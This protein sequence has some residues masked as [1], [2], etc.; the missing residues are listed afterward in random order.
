[1]IDNILRHGNELYNLHI[2]K[3]FSDKPRYLLASELPKT[4]RISNTQ[5]IS[6]QSS[7]FTGLISARQSEA[8][9]LTFSISDG[10]HRCFE[11]SAYCLMTIGKGGSCGYTTAVVKVSDQR[12]L[13]FDSHARDVKGLRSVSGKAVV[14]QASSVLRF[15]QYV[16]DLSK[17][18][19]ADTLI[20]FEL[21]VVSVSCD[22]DDH[23]A[24]Y[25][26]I[27]GDS[28]TNLSPDTLVDDFTCTRKPANQ[29]LHKVKRQR[30][31]ADVSS[32][33]QTRYTDNDFSVFVPV[34]NAGRRL[35]RCSVCFEHQSVATL[36]AAKKNQLPVICTESGTVPRKELL[37]LHLES[38]MHKECV[39][40]QHI[41]KLQPDDP[42]AHATPPVKQMFSI[43]QQKIAGKITGCLYTVFNDAKR[44][45]LS[46]WSWPSR[47]VAHM[48]GT[49]AEQSGLT[50]VS[51]SDIP[52]TNL[53]YI[54]PQM[55]NELLGCIVEADKENVKKKVLNSLAI[56]LRADGSVD[57]TQIDNVHV[58]AKIVTAEGCENNIFLGFKEPESR[59]ADGY[60]TALKDAVEFIVE[61]KEI[62]PKVTSI[63]TDGASINVGDKSGLWA[64]LQKLRDEVEDS[65]TIPLLKIWCTVHRSSL[66][67]KSACSNVS[68]L[69]TLL[70]D[71]TGLAS[72]FRQSG[73]R[74]HEL[75][76][77]AKQKGFPVF[78][79]PKY[80]EVRW[81]EFT[82]ALCHA[83]VG[84]WRAIVTYL[85]SS[86]DDDASGFLVK[87]TEACRIQL[88]FFVT[89]VTFV[90][91]RFQKTLQ[92]DNI[93]LSEISAEV[94]ELRAKLL[95]MQ[96][97]P[98]LGGWEELFTK[99]FTTKTVGTTI[100]SYLHGIELSDKK[101]RRKE[102][103]KL[104]SDRRG[105]APVRSEI[106][107]CLLNFVQ[108][109]LD[110]PQ[111]ECLKLLENL[112][113]DVT[114]NELRECHKV[115]CPDQELLIFAD[116]Y[117]TAAGI[118]QRSHVE[119]ATTAETTKRPAT[120]TSDMSLT[121]QRLLR[122][123]DPQFDVLILSI[124]RTISV[125]PH[126]ADVE[127]LIS[128]YNL[129]KTSDR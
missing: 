63:V 111:F 61:W 79:M 100:T 9:S 125:K 28:P 95:R 72:Y 62:F 127:R 1:M 118:L 19:F 126:S 10:L 26:T 53:Q 5:F 17:S 49:I 67:W 40:M 84:S 47:E 108:D 60:C 91:S 16:H 81:A 32:E 78:S 23:E 94:A 58:M 29:H 105:Y 27:G 65:K 103:H 82:Y 6:S 11:Q 52:N 80:F 46:A 54:N 121:L 24:E 59:G 45:T 101:R 68:E 51:S 48:L 113:A 104:V 3:F 36:F 83:I 69:Q 4:V 88:L 107:M 98:V 56:S 106:I 117:R 86:S 73:I 110:M 129:L 109:R 35:V 123:N 33:I 12:Y 41:A 128:Y 112:R 50:D 92:R 66:A 64:R 89:D 8:D 18:L 87:W 43:Q 114:D 31:G 102:H 122:L 99:F 2:A 34:N 74:T 21:V 38:Q 42:H 14:M 124:A 119:T 70:L 93:V 25:A 44:G 20:P 71:M 57:R 120:K 13:S 116:S 90:F 75:R 76:E 77:T 39:K 115:I 15:V 96:N 85:E 22:S 7:I 30:V 55:H 97:A 37:V